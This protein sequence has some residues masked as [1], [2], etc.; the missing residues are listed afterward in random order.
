MTRMRGAWLDRDC[1]IYPDFPVDLTGFFP[2][3]HL[4]LKLQVTNVKNGEVTAN[5]KPQTLE[6]PKP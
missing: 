4:D 1:V 3:R 5:C 6:N 2:D